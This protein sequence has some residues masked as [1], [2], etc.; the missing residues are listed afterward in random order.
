[1]NTVENAAIPKTT[2]VSIMSAIEPIPKTP[3]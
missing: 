2:P 3:T 1:M